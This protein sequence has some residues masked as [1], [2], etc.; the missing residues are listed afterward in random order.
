LALTFGMTY[1]QYWEKEP[2]LFF[3]YA[4]YY[5]SKSKNDFAEQDTLAWMIGNY[6]CIAVGVNFSAAFGEKGKPKAKYPQQPMFV[7]ELDET[8]KAKKQERKAIA[9][10]ANFLAAVHAMG[11]SIEEA[12]S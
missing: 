3:I 12:A 9:N 1:E 7:S 11:M 10:Q 6:V 5:Q 4:K 8:A 2:E